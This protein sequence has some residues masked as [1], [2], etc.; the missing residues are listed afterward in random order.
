MVTGKNRSVNVNVEFLTS[1][2]SSR[3]HKMYKA[4]DIHV[5]S[6][7]CSGGSAHGIGP[8]D[9]LKCEHVPRGLS[10]LCCLMWSAWRILRIICYRRIDLRSEN[11]L[12]VKLLY[13]VVT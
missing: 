6:N 1:W 13:E 4:W 12:C 2:D 3:V 11:T 8:C 9:C 7:V 5:C 10:I